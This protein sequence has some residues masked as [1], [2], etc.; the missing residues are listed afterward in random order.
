VSSLRRMRSALSSRVKAALVGTWG[1]NGAAP[2]AAAATAKVAGGKAGVHQNGPTAV[3]GKAAAAAK[4]ASKADAAPDAEVPPPTSATFPSP[5]VRAPAASA[6]PLS[7]PLLSQ[8]IKSAGA[9]FTGN[10]A[11]SPVV[12]HPLLQA[13]GGLASGTA[14]PV[15]PEA[16]PVVPED[17][18][19][20]QAVLQA[21][22]VV[23]QDWGEAG[24]EGSE[25]EPV[26]HQS[27]TGNHHT[28]VTMSITMSVSCQI[29]LPQ[30]LPQ[31]FCSS[32]EQHLTGA[33]ASK[34]CVQQL[35]LDL[36]VVA[37]LTHPPAGSAQ[38]NPTQVP[39]AGKLR[40]ETPLMM[41]ISAWCGTCIP[42]LHSAACLLRG[43]LCPLAMAQ[44][45]S[46]STP[47]CATSW[48][49]AALW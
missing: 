15:L 20:L 1:A 35:N 39:Q 30:R 13:A 24:G 49:P 7:S 48:L 46:P 23:M 41:T 11:A 42:S 10:A 21:H 26:N 43:T 31:G 2:T 44:A 28:G 29:S 5:A 37:V 45:Q 22:P 8:S 19:V 25:P 14:S 36:T 47:A 34:Q 9:G 16:H 18:R 17:G 6:Q 4:D 38:G 12:S 40:D 3:V 32:G 27:Q 33:A